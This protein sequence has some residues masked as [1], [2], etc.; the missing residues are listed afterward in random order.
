MQ[1]V[2][3]FRRPFNADL[4]ANWKISV[5]KFTVHVNFDYFEFEL[6][7]QGAFSI[8]FTCYLSKKKKKLSCYLPAF[9]IAEKI[10]KTNFNRNYPVT[11]NMFNLKIQFKI[12]FHIHP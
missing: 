4:H 12:C 8:W 1:I 2:L 3:Y 10:H 9:P 7:K 5:C 11:V 6:N